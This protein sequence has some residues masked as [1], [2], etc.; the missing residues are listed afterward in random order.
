METLTIKH[1][2]ESLFV[3]LETLLDSLLS[4]SMIYIN[5]FEIKDFFSF[6][7]SDERIKFYKNEYLKF[8]SKI[9]LP[10]ECITTKMYMISALLIEADQNILEDTSA[11]L[12][13]VFEEF[14]AFELALSS[15][16]K[17]TKAALSK[18]QLS[19]STLTDCAKKL[20][21]SINALKSKLK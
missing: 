21:F 1:Q 9:A 18:E 11:Q 7:N 19:V 17:E 20:S 15:F 3:E 4:E 5:S 10:L 16:T 6:S 8:S 14:L 2:K 13:A 12:K